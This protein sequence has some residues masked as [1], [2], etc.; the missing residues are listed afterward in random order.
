MSKRLYGVLVIGILAVGCGGAAARTATVARPAV[1]AHWSAYVHVRSPIDVVG[2]RRDGEEVVAADG[3][4][5]LLSRSGAL[6]AFAPGYR[7]NPGLEAYIALADLGHPGCSFGADTVFA[8]S[9]AKPRGV[10]AIDGRGR[11]RPFAAIHAPG[12]IDGIAFDETGRFGYRLLLAT[13]AGKH[14]SVDAVSCHGAVSTITT[15]AHRV[16]GGIA[17][18]PASFGEFAG[19]LIASD[20]LGGGIYAVTPGGANLLVASSGLPHGGDTGV[21]SEAFLPAGRYSALLAD[22]LTPGN[23][24]PGD[25]VLLRLSSAALLAGRRASRRPARRDGGWGEDG[26]RALHVGRVH[27][28]P[29]R[30]WAGDRPPRGAHRDRSVRRAQPSRSITA[31]TTTMTAAS[32]TIVATYACRD[33]DRTAEATRPLTRRDE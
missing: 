32:V 9:F 25:N 29:C 21:E 13:T 4:L 11:V 22:R 18:A 12:L 19:D 17:V 30:R 31:S 2:P 1:P 27:R 10:V 5:W 33:T 28:A 20:E 6:H 3:R 23:R 24:H 8:I 26:G 7:S 15:R 16:E 14:A